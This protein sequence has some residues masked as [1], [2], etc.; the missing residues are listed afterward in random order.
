MTLTS[1]KLKKEIADSGLSLKDEEILL[2]YLSICKTSSQWSAFAG[3]SHVKTE[4]GGYKR[5]WYATDRLIQLSRG[6]K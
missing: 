5:V 6:I 1:K 4:K 3:C 2:W